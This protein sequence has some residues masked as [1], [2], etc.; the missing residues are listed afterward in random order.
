MSKWPRQ[1]RIIVIKPFFWVV[2][3]LPL[4]SNKD[5][6]CCLTYKNHALFEIRYFKIHSLGWERSVRSQ[7]SD[8]I[9]FLLWIFEFW[10][11]VSVLLQATIRVTHPGIP[12]M[13]MMMVMMKQRLNCLN[14]TYRSS[15]FLLVEEH[16]CH[17]QRV[18]KYINPT[19][20]T[21]IVHHSTALQAAPLKLYLNRFDFP[22]FLSARDSMLN[23]FRGF[24]LRISTP[25]I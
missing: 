25:E 8:I 20:C 14:K 7:K 18:R 5:C 11:W 21:S 1:L 9:F 6:L 4:T 12:V 17:C 22:F 19:Y 2:E 15:L 10:V 3:R 16:S 23:N 24:L 13:M